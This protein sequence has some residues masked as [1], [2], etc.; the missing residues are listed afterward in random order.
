MDVTTG[1]VY[2]ELDQA[3]AAGV[4]PQNLVYGMPRAIAELSRAIRTER[5]RAT[6]RARQQRKAAHKAARTSRRRNR[7]S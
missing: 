3:V 4:D 6:E 1:K 7:R 2:L 5:A